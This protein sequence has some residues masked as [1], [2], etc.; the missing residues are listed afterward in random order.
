M[1][2]LPQASPIHQDFEV[3]LFPTPY[4]L[5][6]QYIMVDGMTTGDIAGT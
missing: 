4:G 3:F 2:S 5:P 6:A 1:E